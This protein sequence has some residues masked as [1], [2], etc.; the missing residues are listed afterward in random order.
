ML[1]SARTPAA[2]TDSVGTGTVPGHSN[3]KW[4]V[5]SV[6]S[7]PP[8]LRVRHQC[9]EVF[10]QRC[11]IK[12]FECFGV[13]ESGVH[14]AGNRLVLVQDGEIQ[15]IG[16]PVGIGL[17]AMSGAGTA[18]GLAGNPLVAP[19]RFVGVEPSRRL[20]LEA[21]V[22]AIRA[23]AYDFVTKPIEMEVLALSLERALQQHLG[24]LIALRAVTVE[25]VDARLEV[26]VQYVVLRDRTSQE[27]RFDFDAGSV[28]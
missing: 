6:V 12:F 16:P 27:A 26:T 13:V 14:R 17:G 7:R 3:K 1:P 2:I 24:H 4:T 9:G 20:E 25:P 10:F 19:A 21:A 22:A 15:L 8:V 11:E 18:G 28:S 5:I 23:G